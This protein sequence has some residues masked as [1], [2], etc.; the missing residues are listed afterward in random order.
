MQ[1]GSRKGNKKGL[2]CSRPL[3]WRKGRL[4]Q[5]RPMK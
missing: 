4:L 3:N 2:D 1:G 5:S